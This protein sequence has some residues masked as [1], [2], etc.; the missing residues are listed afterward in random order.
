MQRADAS[1]PAVSA[2]AIAMSGQT[3]MSMATRQKSMASASNRLSVK[4]DSQ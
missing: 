3:G 2:P 4:P 1:L